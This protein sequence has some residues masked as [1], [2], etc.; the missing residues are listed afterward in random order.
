MREPYLDDERDALCFG[1]DSRHE[2]LNRCV[3]IWI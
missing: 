1:K 2:I 3:K